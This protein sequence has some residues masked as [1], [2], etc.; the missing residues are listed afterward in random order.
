MCGVGVIDKPNGKKCNVSIYEKFLCVSILYSEQVFDILSLSI[1]IEIP[2]PYLITE[3][4]Y[5]I[6]FS[7]LQNTYIVKKY[8]EF[9]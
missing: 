1:Q 2:T 3:V 4:L 7:T 6:D 8:Y 5:D 9:F